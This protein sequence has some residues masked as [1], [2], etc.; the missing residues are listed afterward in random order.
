MDSARVSGSFSVYIERYVY[1]SFQL[2][3]LFVGL[4]D[5][6]WLHAL[7]VMCACRSCMM[8]DR[9]CLYVG[10]WQANKWGTRVGFLHV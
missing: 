9:L 8:R 5:S 7:R 4:R 3:R 10:I 1:I 6:L 2:M